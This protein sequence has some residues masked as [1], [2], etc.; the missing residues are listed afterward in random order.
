M[1]EF[2]DEW[3]HWLGDL[4]TAVL[5]CMFQFNNKNTKTSNTFL[6]IIKSCKQ[7]YGILCCFYCWLGTY[8]FFFARLTHFRPMFH[9]YTPKNVRKPLVKWV[10]NISLK[11]V[12]PFLPNVPFLYPLKTSEN[13]KVF[14]CFQEVEKRYIENKWVKVLWIFLL[15]FRGYRNGTLTLNGLIIL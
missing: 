10:W 8:V 2:G 14:W 1:R 3:V 13:R 11:C 5:I 7:V 12:N 4:F 6:A 15:S 9:F